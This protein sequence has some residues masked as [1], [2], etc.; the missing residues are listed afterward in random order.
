MTQSDVHSY[1]INHRAGH[2]A[3]TFIDNSG[4][5]TQPASVR[6]WEHLGSDKTLCPDFPDMC[7]STHT[8]VDPFAGPSVQTTML[9]D[10]AATQSCP[11][12]PMKSQ[13]LEAVIMPP[14]L[15]IPTRTHLIEYAQLSTRGV[16]RALRPSH[17]VWTIPVRSTASRSG[18]DI[19]R[20]HVS[21]GWRST[22]E[23]GRRFHH[24]WNSTSS[25]IA[26]NAPWTAT[27]R[28]K[29]NVAG[30]RERLRP[31]LHADVIEGP[32]QQVRG[33][34]SLVMA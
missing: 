14:G 22:S 20:Q 10:A 25:S 27:S 18:E 28:S 33:F 15:Q 3:P 21:S 32:D 6:D 9:M 4:I 8:M 24:D 19:F 17:S 26:S 16:E 7:S 34:D 13:L 11:K 23:D 31:T 12:S 2:V 5:G 1:S 29:P 30:K